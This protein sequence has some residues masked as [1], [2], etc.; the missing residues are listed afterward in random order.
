VGK[1]TGARLRASGI[2]TIGDVIPWSEGQ[3]VHRFGEIG[4]L[5]YNGA[6]GI[7]RS[8]VQVSHERRSIS[9]ERTFAKDIGD[10]AAIKRALLR[11]SESV[12]RRLRQDH[13][14]AQTIR[15]KVRFTDFTTFTRQSSLEQPTDQTN[16]IYATACELLEKRVPIGISLRLLGV[17]ATGLLDEAGY[18]LD[19]FDRSD[20]RRIHLDETLDDIRERYGK[21]AIMRASLLR[22]R[23]ESRD[24]KG[25]R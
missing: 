12:A 6:R 7:D 19:L 21:D 16:A 24:D 20:Q 17:G 1:T 14:V 8:D 15:I 11:M 5:L 3:L 10:R 18:Q 23:G 22:R 25:R 2:E 4:H 13:L 9:H